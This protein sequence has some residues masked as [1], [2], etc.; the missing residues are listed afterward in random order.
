MI[1]TLAC[2]AV[3][4]AGGRGTRFWP[5]ST[6]R[7]PKQL[8]EVASE[9]SMI[10]ETTGRLEPLVPAERTWVVCG[11]AESEALRA[12]LPEVPVD[13][14]LVEPCGRN[15]AA[16]IAL[17]AHHLEAKFPGALMAVLPADHVIA[18][19]EGL[20]RA[21]A[22]A[23]EAAAAE[24]VLIT[25][26]I[27]PEGPESGYGYI[28]RGA[29]AG[30]VG[31]F[32]QFQVAAFREKPDPMTAS[33]MVAS[34]NYYWNAGMFVWRARVIL[35]EVEAHLPDLARALAPVRAAIG[36]ASLT[37]A[38]AA[39][40]AAI[41]GISIDYGVMERSARVWVQPADFGWNDVGSFRALWEL[42]AAGAGQNATRGQST[43]IDCKKTLAVGQGLRVTAVGVDNL[44]IVATADAVLVCPL[45]RTQEVKRIVEALEEEGREDLL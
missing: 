37:A 39:A 23:F 28:E 13:Q 25:I 30:R 38:T 43:L 10:Q 42:K 2:H 3:I 7:R 6:R 4:M 9:R 16:C 26:G 18:D 34:G 21:L 27:E 29:E 41:D 32:E 8:L 36:T 44:V 11:E 45:D 22:A 12:Q 19:P 33:Q 1:D 5:L 14:I 40:Y 31:G 15:T 17:A 35:E 24:P 20:R